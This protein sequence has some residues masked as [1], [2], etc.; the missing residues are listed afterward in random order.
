MVKRFLILSIISL[1]LLALTI[2]SSPDA[3]AQGSRYEFVVIAQSIGVP[4]WVPVRKGVEDAATM[5]TAGTEDVVEAKLIGTSIMN[6][7]KQV[8]ILDSVIAKNVDGIGLVI[9]DKVAFNNS[10]K[11]AEEKGIPVI[12]VNTDAGESVSKSECPRL[13]YIGEMPI[14]S[15]HKIGERIARSV[16]EGVEVLREVSEPGMVALESRSLGIKEALE[17]HNIKSDEVL[18]TSVETS[19]AVG[20]IKSYLRIHPNLKVVAC[21]NG[22]G[23]INVAQAAKELGY[24][25]G[26]LFITAYN[27]LPRLNSFIEEGYIQVTIDQAPYLQGLYAVIELYL[28]KKYGIMP[29]DIN[30]ATGFG[31][32]D[33]IGEIKELAEKG[34]R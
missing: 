8:D 29:H 3:M 16:P 25:P 31:T 10:L 32:K 26:K 28:Y 27:F 24:P 11:R 13:A 15:G 9:V 22:I 6:V 12:A 5:L 19:V 30:T 21:S 34:Y 4:F 1:G 14:V 2:S 33:N 20:M 18:Y 17:K 7:S 23:A